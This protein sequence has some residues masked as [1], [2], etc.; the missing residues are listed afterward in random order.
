MAIPP[1]I[2]AVNYQ[3][4][5]APNALPPK[6]Q[7]P[8][9]LAW[10]YAL[11]TAVQWIHNLLF[12]DYAFGASYSFWNNSSSYTT[13]QDVIFNNCLT[14]AQ[15]GDNAVYEAIQNVPANTPPVGANVLPD[16]QP[17]WVIDTPSALLWVSQ[18][19]WVKR[20]QNF[21]GATIRASF[22]PLILQFEWALNT[23]FH[24]TIFETSEWNRSGAPPDT[25]IYIKTNTTNNNIGYYFPI[26]NNSFF[27]SDTQANSSFYYPSNQFS[28]AYDFT[29]YVPA[30]VYNS[31][32]NEA[33]GLTPLKTSIVSNFVNLICPAGMYYIV[34][35][36]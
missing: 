19:Y 30:A 7:V 33:P 10:V 35:I 11:F 22:S 27:F 32:S 29:V 15:Y 28:G 26:K 25:Q 20:Q 9:W 13:G 2:Y 4:F 3:S 24:I 31:L 1:G 16:V 23:F 5:I 34:A 18:Y 12:G 14:G 8:W 6:Y 21:I 17:P 36:Y